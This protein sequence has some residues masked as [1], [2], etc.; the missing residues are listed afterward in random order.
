[1][2][3]PE[4]LYAKVKTLNPDTGEWERLLEPQPEVYALPFKTNK[5]YFRIKTDEDGNQVAFGIDKLTIAV[6]RVVEPATP[7][8]YLIPSSLNSQDGVYTIQCRGEIV[9]GTENGNVY[10]LDEFSLGIPQDMYDHLIM[11]QPF[12]MTDRQVAYLITNYAPTFI[13]VLKTLYIVKQDG[14]TL[15]K[16]NNSHI[17]ELIA[18]WC[19]HNNVVLVTELVIGEEVVV[20]APADEQR[21]P[22]GKLLACVVE[23]DTSEDP[24]NVWY[25]LNE[26]ERRQRLLNNPNPRL[27]LQATRD[28]RVISSAAFDKASEIL[29]AISAQGKKVR[30]RNNSLIENT[31]VYWSYPDVI[32]ALER[33]GCEVNEHTIEALT[34]DC[35]WDGWRDRAIESGWE[36]LG[37]AAQRVKDSL[38]KPST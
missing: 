22:A 33:A 27:Y 38:E 15:E 36:F 1:M 25:W 21:T 28:P 31:T 8:E 13:E 12:Y 34:C 37:E 5:K 6:N 19:A 20:L 30:T 18:E 14:R 26:D 16:L 35:N 17:Y 29:E 9:F 23:S 10:T 11:E 2:R 4:L 7:Q 3:D 32:E 24:K